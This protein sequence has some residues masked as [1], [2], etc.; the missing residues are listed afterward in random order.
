MIIQ[1]LCLFETQP[2]LIDSNENY[3]PSDLIDLVH[4]FYGFPELDPFSCELANQTVKAKK[5]FTAKDDGFRQDWRQAKTLWLNPPYS[6]GFVERVVD[7]LIAT[8]NG[9]EAEAFLLTNTDNSTVWYKKALN[10]C[11]RFCLPST[12]LTFYSPKRAQDGKKQNQNRFSQ[13][14]F[15]FGLQPQRFEEIFEGWGTVC[16][17]S[18]W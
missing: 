15:Y 10:R 9:T 16:Q 13:T 3:T 12:R 5:Y 18:K 11:D 8:L 14:L 2:S 4:K 7:K 1:Q 6:V 17:T